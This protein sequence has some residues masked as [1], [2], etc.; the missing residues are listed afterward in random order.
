ME[1]VGRRDDH[2]VQSWKRQFVVSICI[3]A[4]CSVLMFLLIV[5]SLSSRRD[6]DLASIAQRVFSSFALAFV[7]I[8]IY[9]AAVRRGFESFLIREAQSIIRESAHICQLDAPRIV[10]TVI[11]DHVTRSRATVTYVHK[12]AN[13]GGSLVV[14][15]FVE[16]GTL[17]A[18][19]D[20]N[21]ESAVLNATW[22]P[23]IEP[24]PTLRTVN[25]WCGRPFVQEIE[26]IQCVSKVHVRGVAYDVYRVDTRVV[27]ALESS[28]ISYGPGDGH[29]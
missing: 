3:L 21:M 18:N 19:I 22:K 2:P 12:P 11:S 23:A 6:E 20:W 8:I 26:N 10:P 1:L 25:V 4:V 5:F 16:R 24:L 14:T 13:G 28:L 7:P 15:R 9:H 29:D 27:Y 17:S